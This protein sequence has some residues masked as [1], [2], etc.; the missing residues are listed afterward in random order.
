[1]VLIPVVARLMEPNGPD[2]PPVANVAASVD[3][4]LETEW[5]ATQRLPRPLSSH[6]GVGG[7]P[8]SGK[9][10][11][12]L[13]DWHAVLP[14]SSWLEPGLNTGDTCPMVRSALSSCPWLM[15]QK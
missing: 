13:P 15:F 11:R 7:T 1:M 10:G 4:S 6:G 9:R 5:Q 12:G 8:P 3:P 2:E 14:Q